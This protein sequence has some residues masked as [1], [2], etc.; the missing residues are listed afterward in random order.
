M[1]H[2]A[3]YVRGT[4]ATRF[5]AS[6]HEDYKAD[7]D[8]DVSV[9]AQ[10]VRLYFDYHLGRLLRDYMLS[11][12]ASQRDV[13]LLLQSAVRLVFTIALCRDS[14][15]IA[16]ANGIEVNAELLYHRRGVADMV[17][18]TLGHGDH[19]ALGASMV[20][21]DTASESVPVL[22]T[23]IV[24]RAYQLEKLE[25]EPRIL[26]YIDDAYERC[27][28]VTLDYRI[29]VVVAEQDRT[30]RLS[31]DGKLG[32]RLGLTSSLVCGGEETAD[33]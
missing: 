4:F 15:E 20:L 29:R 22:D 18:A 28:P 17:G 24:L 19:A 23:T 11:G 8:R 27:V 7:A 26:D 13:T 14:S 3:E 5:I 21:G 32:P 33:H 10:A 9:E 6:A 16:D 31:G 2:G 30:F 1:T 25:S 12:A